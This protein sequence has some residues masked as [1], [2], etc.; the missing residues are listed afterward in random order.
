MSGGAAGTGWT[1]TQLSR[2][3]APRQA[4]MAERG[5]GLGALASDP[6]SGET[7]GA[8]L[9]PPR[10]QPRPGPAPTCRSRSTLSGDARRPPKT[11]LGQVLGAR[12]YRKRLRWG[13][14]L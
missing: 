6:G 13:K 11:H 2:E 4:P 5:P 8:W 3:Q 10:A 12:L 1:L 14:L 7:P 9:A